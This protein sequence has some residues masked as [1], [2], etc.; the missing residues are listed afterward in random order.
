MIVGVVSS[1]E[2]GYYAFGTTIGVMLRTLPNTLAL[3]LSTRLIQRFGKAK[4]PQ[5]SSTMV[6]V[7]LWVSAYAMAFI[8]G[9]IV[10]I[11]P[12]LLTYA[13]PQYLPEEKVIGTLVIAN[14]LLFSVPKTSSFLLANEKKR[15]LFAT[16]CVATVAESILVF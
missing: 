11:L 1:R 3:M 14:S 4:D 12:C 2:F 7:S 15:V 5:D 6:L 9:G 8:V 13:S 16:L 10:L